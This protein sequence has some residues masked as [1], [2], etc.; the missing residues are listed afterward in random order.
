MTPKENIVPP[1]GFHYKDPAG[2]TV[3]GH[4]YQSVADNLMRYRVDNKLP[5]GNPLKD[6]FDYV[7]NN[8]PHF[9]TAHNPVL[10]GGN[11]KPSLASR[12]SMWLSNLY[13]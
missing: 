7:C 2:Y 4:S 10:H 9:C 12:V 8:W 13:H 5:V 1:G 11:G 6:V 3:E